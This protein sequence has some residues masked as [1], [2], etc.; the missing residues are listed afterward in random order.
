LAWGDGNIDADPCFAIFDPNGDPNL[1]DLHLKSIY[2]R[3]N[4]AFY[5]ID[6]NKDEVINLIDFAAL[7]GVWM[8]EGIFDEDLNNNGTIDITDLELFVDYY[9][10]KSREDGWLTDASTSPCIDAGD[11]N[12]DFS[13]E[14]W[15]HGM[16]VNM[17]AYGG[18]N[19]ASRNG[20]PADFD[21]SGEVNLVDFA[22]LAGRWMMQGGFIEDLSGNDEIDYADVSIFAENW[23]WQRD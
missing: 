18:T 14:S 20:N 23:L 4:P 10:A 3:W 19:Q 6:F 22:G 7:A 12:S 15:P 21:V 17:G 16:R 9:L 2:G 1:W 8:K 5:K 13:G 11:P